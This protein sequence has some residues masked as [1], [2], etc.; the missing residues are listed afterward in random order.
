MFIILLLS[1]RESGIL[2]VKEFTCL[3]ENSDLETNR[4]RNRGESGETDSGRTDCDE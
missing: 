2:K 3:K 1:D 4:Q